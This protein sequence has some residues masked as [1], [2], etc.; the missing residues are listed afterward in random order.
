MSRVPESRLNLCVHFGA[1]VSS[2]TP[3]NL[4]PSGLT[5]PPLPPFFSSSFSSCPPP[6]LGVPNVTLTWSAPRDFY[7][8]PG[9]PSL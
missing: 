1:R 3:K 6:V 2:R 7:Q 9:P 5:P 4:S 8:T